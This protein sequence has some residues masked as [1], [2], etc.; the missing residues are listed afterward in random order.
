MIQYSSGERSE[1][2]GARSSERSPPGAFFTD[3]AS[4]NGY[5]QSMVN[6]ARHRPQYE[7][8]TVNYVEVCATSNCVLISTCCLYSIGKSN[9]QLDLCEQGHKISTERWDGLG[10]AADPRCILF[11]ASV[12]LG[13]VSTRSCRLMRNLCHKPSSETLYYLGR[14]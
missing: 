10:V 11:M 5:G 7:S 8:H 1:D 9:C 2:L 12:T 4:R 14:V 13:P 3:I 6:E